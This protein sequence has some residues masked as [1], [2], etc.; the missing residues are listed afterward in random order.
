MNREMLE[1][2]EVLAQEKSVPREVVF[3]VLE[4]ALASAVKK[5]NFA[6]EDADVEVHVDR[7]TGDYRAWRRWLIVA[8][9]QGLQEPDRQEM[10]SDIHDQYPDLN[11][12]DYIRV[13]VQNINSSGRRFAQDAKQVILQRLRDAEREQMLVEFLA[14][15]EKVVSGLVKRMDKG[16]AIVEI[17]KVEA[18]LPRSE[19]LPKESFR[20]GDRV[21][22]YVARV[23]RTCKGQQVFLS[24]TSPE[25]IKELFALQVPEIEEIKSAARDPGSR[26]KIAVQ[27]KD[28]RLDPVGTCIG[29][30]G[31]RVNAVSNELG[32]ERVDIVVWDDEPAQFVVSALEPAKVSGVVMLE[33]THTMEV[34]VDEEN[35]AIAIGRAGQNVR[36]AS[37]LTGW[38]IDIMTDEEANAKRDEETSKIRSEFVEKLEVGEDVAD[39]LIENGFSSIEEVAYVPESELLEIEAFDADTVKELRER[40]RNKCLMQDL[41][42]EENLRQA[43]PEMVALEGMDND[44]VNVL[45]AH[46]VKTRDDLAELAVDEL[47]EMSGIEEERASKLILAARAHWFNK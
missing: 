28:A 4:T 3:G 18:R 20:P 33:D 47:V 23:D 40:A 15:D 2:V 8:D 27:A 36:L 25:F 46:G 6:G 32:G 34:V 12:G 39:I 41:E 19:M 21:R 16:D 5:A 14:R 37:E 1:M 11:V 38:K 29:V 44:L 26:A 10:F 43:E 45:V 31:T 17:G 35:L 13:E 42:R 9:D 30:R 7:D 24:R 22:A